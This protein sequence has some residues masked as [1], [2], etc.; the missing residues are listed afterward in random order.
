MTPAMNQQVIAR[1]AADLNG[2]SPHMA[3]DPATLRYD[4]LSGT[5]ATSVGYRLR[6][7]GDL[8]AER[9]LFVKQYTLAD[10]ERRQL[11]TDYA[12]A[13][14]LAAELGDRSDPQVA[15][16]MF[17]LPEEQV[18]VKPYVAGANLGP[19]FFRRLRWGYVP[20]AVAED[21]LTLAG[22]LGIALL[23]LQRIP[24]ERVQ[25]FYG[26]PGPA[27]ALEGLRTQLAGYVEFYRTAGCCVGLVER[28]AT[29]IEETVAEFLAC[30][31]QGCFQHNDYT[32]QNFLLGTDGQLHLFDFA[33]STC[34]CSCFDAAHMLNSFEDMAYLRSVSLEMIERLQRA[35]LRPLLQ[36]PDFRPRL[37]AAMRAYIQLYSSTILLG[38]GSSR[39]H[40]SL[41]RLLKVSPQRRLE[42]MLRARL[43]ELAG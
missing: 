21:L 16:P 42:R 10:V 23:R 6:L 36:T 25:L 30:E 38:A 5:G 29:E 9:D 26:R 33:N 41:R 4:Q 35:F 19:Y 24:A 7:D 20:P 15:A 31:P 14:W 17:V 40:A 12:T 39:R 32:L 11:M 22:R 2:S 1:I 34:G 28:V 13:C 8:G 18:I 27:P 3:S 37:L 43:A